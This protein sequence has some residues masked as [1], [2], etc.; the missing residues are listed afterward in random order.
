MKPVQPQCDY[1][2]VFN[3]Y[4]RPKGT[5]VKGKQRYGISPRQAITLRKK[6]GK[7]QRNICTYCKNKTNKH[8]LDHIIPFA[9]L[10]PYTLFIENLCFCC[11]ECNRKKKNFFL[12]D[13]ENE[14]RKDTTKNV[15]LV[16][17]KLIDEHK[18]RIPWRKEWV[19]T[20]YA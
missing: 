3:P 1:A 13:G 6:L 4:R 7:I 11:Q 20:Y 8:S 18:D 19:H 15:L 17:K 5:V 9:L 12:G 2:M 16:Q 10:E 14:L